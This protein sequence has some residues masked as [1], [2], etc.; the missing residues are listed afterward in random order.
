MEYFVISAKFVPLKYYTLVSSQLDRLASF[1]VG[2]SGR[3]ILSPGQ[4][5]IMRKWSIGNHSGN[6][7]DWTRACDQL[8]LIGILTI[9]T[10]PVGGDFWSIVRGKLHPKLKLSMCRALSQSYIN[11]FMKYYMTILKNLSE[12]LKNSIIL[13]GQVVLELLIKIIFCKLWSI[14]QKLFGQNFNASF[15]FLRQFTSVCLIL[16]FSKS[17]HNF[18]IAHMHN[19]TKHAQLRFGVQFPVQFSIYIHYTGIVD[20]LI[21]ITG[22]SVAS[23]TVIDKTIDMKGTGGGGHS[24]WKVVRG[25][26]GVMNPF[27]QDSRR[28][29]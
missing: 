29:L 5:N 4:I 15:E 7:D 27:F 10:N 19:F 12:E 6:Y 11:S 25:C 26:A 24:P 18:E 16:F 17:I 9:I 23:M 28:S 22:F 8:R 14:A 21:I 20:N 1:S 13:V 3:R 2:C